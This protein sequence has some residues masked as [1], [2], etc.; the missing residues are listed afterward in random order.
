MKEFLPTVVADIPIFITHLLC[1]LHAVRASCA[2]STGNTV[3]AAG[4]GFTQGCHVRSVP[5]FLCPSAGV[6]EWCRFHRGLW[7]PCRIVGV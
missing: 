7:D 4:C 2:C 1:V 5:L 3:Q 6:K